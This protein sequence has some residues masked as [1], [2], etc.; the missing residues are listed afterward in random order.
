MVAM[1]ISGVTQGLMWRAQTDTGA[2]QY[3]NF[4]ETLIAIRAMY[5]MRLFGGLLYLSGFV[6]M[7]W[8][9]VA[10][11]RQGKAVDGET[12]VSVE[13]PKEQ[14]PSGIQILFG[15][16]VLLATV[17]IALI[18]SIAFLPPMVSAVIVVVALVVG[19]IGTFRM[20]RHWGTE[21]PSWHRFLEGRS[22]IFTVITVV[23]VLI[24]G[25]AELVPTVVAGNAALGQTKTKPYTPLELEGRDIYLREGCYLCHSQ[26]IRPFTWETAR[27]GKV[28][29]PDDSIFDHPFQWGS[30]RTGPDLARVGKRYP[31][32]WHYEHMRD[33]RQVSP[34]SNMPNYPHLETARI[35]F[36]ATSKKLDAM[37]VVGVPY[38]EDQVSGAEIEAIL[39]A[40]DIV[41]NLKSQGNIDIAVDSELVALIAYLQRLGRPDPD[42]VAL[43]PT[44]TD[45]SNASNL[46]AR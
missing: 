24:G 29:E 22:A 16:P 33:P 8:N 37:Q 5:W 2:L 28:S 17:V 43:G 10:T 26:M 13:S 38:T 34:G 35:D 39:Q 44:P 30:K 11:A 42:A 3:P 18:A 20:V 45:S 32:L 1:W 4:V 46:E 7:A 21:R 23:A 9:L 14:E 41:L 31:D 19:G 6:L 25:I 27:Y 12:E 15:A 36:K 40:E